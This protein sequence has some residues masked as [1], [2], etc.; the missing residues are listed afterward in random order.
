MSIV[1]VLLAIVVA[2]GGVVAVAAGSTRMAVIGLV[3]A[4]AGSAAVG[5]PAPGPLAI[6]AGGLG[7]LLAGYLLWMAVRR[8]PAH[9]PGIAIGWPGAA[10]AGVAGFVIGWLAAGALGSALA[11][12]G[13]DGPGPGSLGGALIAGSAVA[14]AA[15]GAAVALATVAAIPV[16]VARDLLRT[17]I[18]L[19]ALLGAVGLLRNALGG[20]G[21]AVLVLG[22]AVLVVLAG[23]A[24]AGVI[25][26]ALRRTGDLV[27]HDGLRRDP[28]V[29][30]RAA[31]DAHSTVESGR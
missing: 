15:L 17:G 18:G 29:R 22:L 14:Q 23:A 3:V 19:L 21:D 10:A 20:A 28:A 4:L 25:D 30:H 12:G 2:A 26:A 1:L 31:D 8:A 16:L 27:L 24:V 13:G 9:V 6:L 11:G 7:A 5:D